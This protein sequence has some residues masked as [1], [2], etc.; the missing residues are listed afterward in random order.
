MTFLDLLKKELF[1]LNAYSSRYKEQ[2]LLKHKTGTSAILTVKTKVCYLRKKH[3]FNRVYYFHIK[4]IN[5]R[6]V[7]R[8]WDLYHE[9]ALVLLILKIEV[10]EFHLKTL[11][12]IISCNCCRYVWCNY[13]TLSTM[14]SDKQFTSLSSVFY[15]ILAMPRWWLNQGLIFFAKEKLKLSIYRWECKLWI[16]I[17]LQADL[18]PDTCLAYLYRQM[19]LFQLF[20]FCYIYLRIFESNLFC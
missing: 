15:K 6:N 2:I 8:K 19:F 9:I 3:L 13:F 10:S 11:I 4:T 16:R 12:G 1:N 17:K 18:P 7:A 14:L 5:L 20:N